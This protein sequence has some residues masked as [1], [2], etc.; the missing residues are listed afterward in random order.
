MNFSDDELGIKL[1]ELVELICDGVSRAPIE[2]ARS[3][4]SSGSITDYVILDDI[5][6]LNT[7]KHLVIYTPESFLDVQIFSSKNPLE[8]HVLINYDQIQVDS[9]IIADG[10]LKY[11]E[12][13]KIAAYFSLSTMQKI[14]SYLRK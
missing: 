4:T 13:V 2:L 7:P 14:L 8:L 3:K 11:K 6:G 5:S 1:E 12:M 9:N 10:S